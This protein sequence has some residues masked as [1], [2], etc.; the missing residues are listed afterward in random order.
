V[1]YEGSGLTDRRWFHADERGSVVAISNASGTSIGTNG[2]DDQGVP[3]SSNTWR[4]QFTGQAW[5]P[6][7][8]MYYFKARVYSPTLA[9]FLQTD[10]IGYDDGLNWYNYAHSDPVNGKDPSGLLEYTCHGASGSCSAGVENAALDAIVVNGLRNFCITCT[11]YTNPIISG[12]FNGAMPSVGDWTASLNGRGIQQDGKPPSGPC[13]RSNT[14][15]SSARSVLETAATGADAATVGLAAGGVTGPAAVGA[16]V[17]G[18]VM[19]AGIGTVNAYDAYANGNWGPL[20][21]QGASLGARLVPGGRT[22][23]GA[24]KSAR[25]STGLLRNS[26]GMFRSSY[27]NNPAVEELGNI[28]TQKF[29]GGAVRAAVCGKQ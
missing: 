15:L 28:V 17:F 16:K 10:P 26:A 19:E 23:Q 7:L 24:L 22:L 4:F 6:D 27:I 5:L 12:S 3:G 13:S 8:G 14:L 1:W 21:E 18:Y 9:R 2:Y 11:V 20:A 29:F 25:G